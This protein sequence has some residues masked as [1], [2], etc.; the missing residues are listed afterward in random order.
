MPLG[1]HRNAEARVL[2]EPSTSSDADALRADDDCRD[3][4]TGAGQRGHLGHQDPNWTCPKQDV[5]Q[6]DVSCVC[7][8][9]QLDFLPFSLYN[10]HNCHKRGIFACLPHLQMHLTLPF[11]AAACAGLQRGN[12]SA[13][14]AADATSGGQTH[15]FYDMETIQ[16]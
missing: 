6:K 12:A 1:R 4:K 3:H 8:V 13:D 10:C 15:G 7:W 5:G 11:C 16:K 9:L 14:A 2:S